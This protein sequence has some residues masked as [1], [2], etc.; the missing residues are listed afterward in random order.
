MTGPITM[1]HLRRLTFRA[2]DI[3][4]PVGDYEL[5]FENRAGLFKLAPKDGGNY[6]GSVGARPVVAH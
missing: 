1:L 6:A 3:S 4:Q 2:G 5:G